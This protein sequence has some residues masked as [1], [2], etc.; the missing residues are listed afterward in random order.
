MGVPQ[1]FESIE[2]VGRMQRSDAGL[3]YEHALKEFAR[4]RKSTDPKVVEAIRA[5]NAAIYGLR[6]RSTTASVH[7]DVALNNMSTQYAND[8]FIGYR[9]MPVVDTKG[10]LSGKYYSHT[11]A[12]H[13]S[14]PS[15]AVGERGIP[16]ETGHSVTSSTVT[17]APEALREFVSASTIA[18]QDEILD[19][20]FDAQQGPMQGMALAQEMAHAAALCTS[21]NY[22]S[23]TNAPSTPWTTTASADVIGDVMVA[24]AALFVSQTPVKRLGF[25]GT[26]VWNNI[27]K[28]AKIQEL[29]KYTQSGLPL[30][31]VIAEILELD[32]ILVGRAR[33]NTAQS[34]VTASYARVWTDTVF[35]VVQVA[36]VPSP[37]QL[38]FG[39][40]YQDRPGPTNTITYD[41][42]V[43]TDGGW[44]TKTAIN[45]VTQICNAD[46]GYLLTSV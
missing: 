36:M 28:N 43:G 17:L 45:R 46:A 15:T 13:F 34:G 16:N 3:D 22:G 27:R 35:G 6:Y 23:N 14:H 24:N 11:K 19:E 42:A 5:A 1:N 41:G 38:A 18:N 21:A 37:R 32:D 44:Y 39:Y 4:L 9:L 31:R 29:T 25:C 2:G 40:T 7:T 30:T 33:K 26:T 12:D 10:K 8:V 20:M